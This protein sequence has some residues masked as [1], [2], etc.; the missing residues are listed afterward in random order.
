MGGKMG[1]LIETPEISCLP[2][3]DSM[4]FILMG[5]DGIFDVFSSE[6]LNKF[7]WE[8]IGDRRGDEMKKIMSSIIP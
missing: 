3:D 5:C 7:I 1:I 6:E 8:K 2:L 4:D